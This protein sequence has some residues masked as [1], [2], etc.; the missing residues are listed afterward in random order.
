MQETEQRFT[1]SHLSVKISIPQTFHN[2]CANA[3]MEEKKKSLLLVKGTKWN[4]EGEQGVL[5]EELEEEIV[6]P[7]TT[8]QP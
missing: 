2:Y 6:K 4:R 1:L 3:K 5:K 8:Y 7:N